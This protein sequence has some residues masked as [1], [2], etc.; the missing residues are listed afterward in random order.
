MMHLDSKPAAPNI[1]THAPKELS[2]DA[3][4][5][6]LLEWS[7]KK[8]I[9]KDLKEVSNT[10]IRKLLLEESDD[11]QITSVEILKQF[12]KIDIAVII[13]EEYFIIIEDKTHTG[14]HGNQLERYREAAN[15][16][17]ERRKVTLTLKTIYLKTGNDSKNAKRIIETGDD[18]IIVNRGAILDIL[19]DCDSS[20]HI[21]NDFVRHLKSIEERT[22]SFNSKKCLAS[23]LR[24][25]EGFYMYLEDFLEDKDTRWAI[26][27]GRDSY[28]FYHR[29]EFEGFRLK[30]QF[31]QVPDRS[32]TL[33]VFMIN[34]KKES[35][36]HIRQV[37]L[38][39]KKQP[40]FKKLDYKVSIRSARK[41][42]ILI[43]KDPFNAKDSDNID[44]DHFKKCLGSMESL[45]DEYVNEFGGLKKSQVM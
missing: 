26:E 1:F 18:Y 14:Q 31:I 9:D 16:E 40:S 5:I 20:N 4:F 35:K 24:A 17:I 8:V 33:A 42:S 44:M 11:Y 41:T 15:A 25:A 37:V 27:R 36:N 6:W 32:L 38:N 30:I 2:Q 21:F 45:L 28:F 39:L 12:K 10:F 34:D 29:K 3:F 23:D 22:K 13:N 7:D 43:V 19:D